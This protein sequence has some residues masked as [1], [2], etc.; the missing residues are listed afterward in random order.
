[1]SNKSSHLIVTQ[2]FSSQLNE[3]PK[4]SIIQDCCTC[5]VTLYSEDFVQKLSQNSGC[6]IL[7]SCKE[8]SGALCSNAC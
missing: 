2:N 4:E 6:E 8:H 1:M 7:M 5:F 3:L